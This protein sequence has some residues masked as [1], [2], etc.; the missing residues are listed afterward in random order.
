MNAYFIS[1]SDF[2]TFFSKMI[3]ERNVVGPKAKKSKF[4]FGEINKMEDLRLDYDVTILPPKKVIMP[5]CQTLVTFDGKNYKGN[6]DSSPVVLFGVH[7]Y[8]IKGLDMT[9]KLFSENNLDVNYVAKREATTVVGSNIQKISPRGFW[10][11]VGKNVTAKGHDAF[12]TKI[13]S[14]YLF[15]TLSQKGEDLVQFGTFAKASSAQVGEGKKVNDEVMNKC[16]SKL[17]YSSEEIAKKVRDSFKNQEL[18]ANLA[19]DCFSCG[20]CNTTCPTCYCFDVQDKW[21][22]DQV[23]GSRMRYWDSCLTEDFAKVS[24]GAGAE[25]NFR[26]TRGERFRHRIMRK[27]SYLNE[28]LGGPACTGCGRC[29]TACTA[30]IADPVNVINKIM[31]V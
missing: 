24:L 10:G 30:D 13:N 8:D 27:A 20:S 31:E 29:S 6:V 14:G 16:N 26:E 17:K 11:S 1:E 7:F 19:E 21:N 18:W 2:R 23:S 9:D 12:L 22:L 15:E 25:E 28:K 5:T 4:V 3:S